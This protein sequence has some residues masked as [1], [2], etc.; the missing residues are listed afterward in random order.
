MSEEVLQIGVKRKEMKG[1]E[2]RERH[3]QL[4]AEF[5]RIARRDMKAFLYIFFLFVFLLILFY[6]K[7]Y[8]IVLVLPNIKM[9]LPQVYMCSPS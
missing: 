3:T 9:N 4:N 2:E 5:Q 1:K 8:K 6:F 7:L